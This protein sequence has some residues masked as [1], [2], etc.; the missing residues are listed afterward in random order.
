MNENCVIHM[1]VMLQMPKNMVFLFFDT[2][3][4]F[5]KACFL[6]LGICLFPSGVSS[7]QDMPV[8][9][10]GIINQYS[11]VIGIDTG[12]NFVEVINPN[13][14][15]PG[16]F[17]LLIQMQGAQINE[18][19]SSN[20]GDIIDF[21][22]A[23]NFE[24]AEV[25]VTIENR[26]YFKESIVQNYNPA[27][28]VQLVRTPVY[29]DAIVMSE[30]TCPAWNGETGGII[31]V[32]CEG[33]LELRAGLNNSGR[34]FRGGR[35]INFQI[36]ECTYVDYFASL[37]AGIGGQKGEGIASYIAGK[38]YARGKNANGGGGGNVHNTGGGGGSNAGTGGMGGSEWTGCSN[39]STN[40]GIGGAAINYTSTGQK[41]FMGGGG[42]GANQNDGVG[43]I[44]V[45]G[46]GIIILQFNELIANNQ[47]INAS[48]ANQT[49]NAGNDSGGGGGAG[50]SV[51]LSGTQISGTLNVNVQGGFGGGI[52][53]PAF[54][55]NDKWGP[56]GGGGGGLVWLNISLAVGTVA[57]TLNGG[58]AGNTPNNIMWGAT[59]GQSG[60]LLDGLVIS[61][62]TP[63]TDKYSDQYLVFC[64]DNAELFLNLDC[65]ESTNWVVPYSD[66]IIMSDELNIT[67]LDTAMQIIGICGNKFC[68]DSIVIFHIEFEGQA[69]TTQI[70]EFICEGEIFEF[71]GDSLSLPGIYPFIY[72]NT[73]GCDSIINI[74]L[75]VQDT[76]ITMINET[77]CDGGQYLF[78]GEFLDSEGLYEVLL[79]NTMG[80]DSLVVLD[81]KVINTQENEIYA[82][83]CIGSEYL[84]DE[85]SYSQSGTYTAIFQDI[86]GCDSIVTLN[87]EIASTIEVSLSASICQGETFSFGTQTLS[88]PGRYVN[89]FTNP[90]GCDS[91]T[92]LDLSVNAS[93]HDLIEAVICKGE[94][95]KLNDILYD[96]D[97]IYI[98][99]LQTTL[100]CDSIVSL[101]LTVSAPEPALGPNREFCP[102]LDTIFLFPGNF[103]FY[104]WNDGSVSSQLRVESA[105]LYYVQVTDQ[106]GC[107]GIDSISLMEYCEL[108]F[109]IPEAFSPNADG[110][111]DV[112]QV[113]FSHQPESFELQIF[114][115]WGERIA[116]ITDPTK[117]WDG[118]FKGKDAPASVY[119]WLANIEG[120][121]YSGDLLLHR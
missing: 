46:G 86:N 85:I 58:R 108:K 88:I 71:N 110:I 101:N 26:I 82:T 96:T 56:G 33:T 119:V 27:S 77:I 16:D 62:G 69:T 44:G 23:G 104:L 89:D 10:G 4:L 7:A 47:N 24:Y 8:E 36:Q 29:Q 43:T 35:L 73:F 38:D 25:L 30:I 121:T 84:F 65:N 42:G 98:D 114:D 78:Q 100:G 107:K 31:S 115:R 54:S 79:Q 120:K 17:V 92:T 80:C 1:R 32:I 11:K 14:F 28:S 12:C 53:H 64:K 59:G 109:F 48:G 6:I 9:I 15:S 39:A 97:G 111:N 99:S 68:P 3:R 81:L 103:S 37:Q 57:A 50:G 40:V 49:I 112:F 2:I 19:N 60:R 75:T 34:G 18:T 106:F 113:F 70:S 74:Q 94:T 83:I 52:Q 5:A 90:F 66:D 13:Y 87:L 102:E 72:T 63:N 67:G 95:Y 93:Y 116:L 118:K 61:Q 91:T 45:A 117:G 22:E 20:F 51:L 41:V 76:N 105:G 21:H 55:N